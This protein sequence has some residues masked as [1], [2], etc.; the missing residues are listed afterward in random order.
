[1]SDRRELPGVGIGPAQHLAPVGGQPFGVLRMQTRMAERMLG[2]G[3][4]EAALVPC[5]AGLTPRRFE[6]LRSQ[7]VPRRRWW[8]ATISSSGSGST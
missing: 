7:I 4:G 6:R 8:S 1:V 3:V 2:L 5:E